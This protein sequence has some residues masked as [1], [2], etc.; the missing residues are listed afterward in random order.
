MLCGYNQASCEHNEIDVVR[1]QFRQQCLVECFSRCKGLRGKAYRIN[2]LLFRTLQRIRSCIVADDNRNLR[3]CDGFPRQ[4]HPELPADSSPPETRTANLSI[5]VL[6]FLRFQ[7]GR[8][9]MAYLLPG[10]DGFHRCV[11]IFRINSQY[12]TDTHVE[13]VVHHLLVDIAF[14][15][16]QIKDRRYGVAVFLVQQLRCCL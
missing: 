6:L 8:S 5:T 7:C 12:H 3:V 4:S 1:L 9:H 11:Y 14:L 15:C 2:L 10:T 16:H 13:G